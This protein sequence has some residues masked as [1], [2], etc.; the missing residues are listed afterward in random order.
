MPIRD[1]V[2]VVNDAPQSNLEDKLGDYFDVNTYITEIAIQNFM[3]QSD[4]LLGDV[5]MNNFFLYRFA[6][7]RMSVL[8]PWDQ[9]NAFNALDVTPWQNMST[10]VLAAKIWDEPKYR[11]AYLKRLLEVADATGPPSGASGVDGWLRQE[12][13]REYE[14]I[15]D[16]V[17]VDP[18]TPYSTED[19]EQ[20][21]AAIDQFARARADVVRQY[22]ARVA[23]ELLTAVRLPSVQRLPMGVS[24]PAVRPTAAR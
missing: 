2:Q 8:I 22:V 14:Q 5:G 10:N 23:P 20:S 4:G 11:N 16:A 9:D 17:Y 15:R 19:F 13:S 21:V 24:K 18:L 3:A 7:K 6:G 1:L 12:A